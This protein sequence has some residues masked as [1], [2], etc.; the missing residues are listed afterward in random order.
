MRPRLPLALA[1]VLFVLT[2]FAAFAEE[3]HE[4]TFDAARISATSARQR[5]SIPASAEERR[6]RSEFEVR[7]IDE[8]YGVPSFVWAPRRAG[9]RPAAG[10]RSAPARTADAAA[11]AHLG[12]M[13]PLYRLERGDLEGVKLR[14]LHDTG[15]GAIIAT[16]A[17]VVD[18]I[19]VFRDEFKV[20]MD[21]SQE[22]VSVSGHLP[23]RRLASAGEART[24]ART[25][26]QAV[27][28]AL[29]DFAGLAAAPV[30]GKGLETDAAG[31]ERFEAPEAVR[32]L[33]DGRAIARPLRVRPVWFH[34]PESLE[35]AHQVEVMGEGAAYAYVFSASDGRLLFKHSLMQ[36]VAYS[37]RV[38]ADA[39]SPFQPFDGPQGAAPSPHPTGTVDFYN[40]AL[41]APSLV[42]L[43]NGP[44][45][46]NDPWLPPGATETVGNN[47][48]A[49][50]DIASPDGR[51]AGD[52][53]AAITAPD[54]FDHTYNTALAPSVSVAQ[55]SG[56]ITTLFYLNNYLHDWFYDSGFDEASGNAQTDNFGR[57]GVG[58][59]AILAEGQDYGGTN[60]ANMS[61]PSDGG[62]PRMQMY[63]FNVSSGQVVVTSPG[64]IAG[65]YVASVATGFG[66]QTF[67]LSGAVAEAL[68]GTAPTTDICTAVVNGAAIAGKI[69]LI[70]RGICNFNSK[71]QFA[72][73]AG[74]IGVILV[75]NVD[76]T[77][78]SGVTGS[79]GTITIPTVMVS[80][81]VGNAIRAQLGAGVNVTLIRQA[82]VARDGTI[83]GH[84]VAHEWGHYLSN[85]LV[86][87]AVGLSTNQAGGMGEGWSDFIAL[88]LA[89]RPADAASNFAGVYNVGP[90]ALS[91]SGVPNH[92]YYF[93]IRRYPYS[94]DMTKAPL[95][96]RHIVPFNALPA[97][98]PV[99]SN[100]DPAGSNNN[101]VHR[102]GEVW[103]NMLWECYTALLR[104]SGRLTFTE[105]S[106]RMRD[107][108]VA[109]FKLTPD[110]PT[111]IDARDALL[112]A[113]IAGDPADFSLFVQAF[114]KRGLGIGA[115]AGS[116]DDN[117]GAVESF[118]VGGDL[119]IA[120]LT[121]TDDLHTCD[122]DGYLDNGETATLRIEVLNNGAT[123]LSSTSVTVSSPSG[124]VSFPGGNV[125]AM[126]ASTAFTS[127]AVE[128]PVDLSG[129]AGA[130]PLTLNVSVND[131]G[132]LQAGPRTASLH[133][134]AHADE[135]TGTTDTAEPHTTAW[136][137]DAAPG[138]PATPWRRLQVTPT[139]HEYHLPDLGG[140]ADVRFV[141]PPMNVH[142]TQPLS[143]SF[144][145][146]YS[147]EWDASFNY[148]GGVIE[149]SNN[150]GGSWTDVGASTAPTYNGSLNGAGNPLATRNG[151]VRVSAGYP[152]MIPTT[153][154][155]GNTY[156]GQTVQ[157]RFRHGADPGVGGP[158]WWFD[159]FAVSGITNSPFVTLIGE[160]GSCT[161]LATGPVLPA[162]LALAVSGRHPAA[163][164]ARLRFS[165][166]SAQRVT[167]TMHDLAG[168][169]VATLAEGEYS[170]GHHEASFA[171]TSAGSLPG[172]GIY[173]AR[174]TAGAER[175]TRQVVLV[176]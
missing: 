29:E 81:Q 90:Y 162:S 144:Q 36:D 19:E 49:Y 109:G 129:A 80:Q 161:P 164:T 175:I 118:A 73:N 85:R 101:Q 107:Y 135:G 26:E 84:I 56:S 108:L 70:D 30:V 134:W 74:A 137:T 115:V 37:Y 3:G 8:R 46:T 57:G 52:F 78:P 2:A 11:R 79:S 99:N 54:V 43:Q 112:A 131:P 136:T 39:A 31:F 51:T 146:R 151:F 17:Q 65:T 159:D 23:S 44:I 38:W 28:S 61:T 142:A 154:S 114:A 160:T 120:S 58:G 174:L 42:T 124:G 20:A 128:I 18:G 66:P 16:Y 163:G 157:F 95:T 86:G 41:I 176:R 133:D 155:L 92:A 6:L 45:S 47:V 145:H 32:Q 76:V 89:A 125:V 132:L 55:R 104:D 21:R 7:S 63:V 62:A 147:F 5:L 130:S 69:A 126:P 13:A 53:R 77:V 97:G 59:D 149:I 167:L 168:R 111:L 9:D 34:L 88:L 103:C 123:T 171:R 156:A 93:A 110:A 10:L 117:T 87:N 64:A 148:D 12:A 116:P 158:G 60:N 71:V 94:T 33:P 138:S 75:N 48:D 173:F 141:S 106:R 82:N 96:Y 169:L 24:F 67:N 143:I 68:D 98:I 100:A 153:I 35:P 113:A 105:A 121:L 1:S 4:P 27:A 170:A 25:A 72:Q 22:L 50:V 40:P 172:A 91:A 127:V 140:T 122:G 139:D 15:R 165:L 14:H 119:R 152:A 150:G 102:T 83:D 166:P